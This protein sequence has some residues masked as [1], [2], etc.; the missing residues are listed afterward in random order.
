MPNA[1]HPFLKLPVVGAMDVPEVV[2]PACVAFGF[3]FC[4]G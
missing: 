4:F 3:S 2:I 1:P